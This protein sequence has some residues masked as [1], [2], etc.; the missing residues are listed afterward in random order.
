[1]GIG[2]VAAAACSIRRSPTQRTGLFFRAALMR[3]CQP[4]PL[5]P[6]AL[7]D[8]AVQPQSHGDLG[9][10]FDRSTDPTHDAGDRPRQIG[11]GV[12]VG[13]D[14]ARDLSVLTRARAFEFA[15]HSKPPLDYCLSGR[16]ITTIAIAHGEDDDVEAGSQ[17]GHRDKARL[18]VISAAV[19][20]DH[21]AMPIQPRQVAKIDAMVRQIAEALVFVP[22]GHW[23]L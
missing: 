13:G 22:G 5:G 18:A 3:V 12:G 15:S 2:A 1:L 20:E 19:L 6:E 11:G 21:R 14:G 7:D 16:D 23:F 9:I 8:V 4:G 10:R 17:L